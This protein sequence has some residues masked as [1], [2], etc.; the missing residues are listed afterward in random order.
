M[1]GESGLKPGPTKP[2][3]KIRNTPDL[4]PFYSVLFCFYKSDV[5]H[6]NSLNHSPKL[7]VSVTAIYRQ[8]NDGDPHDWSTIFSKGPIFY[9]KNLGFPFRQFSGGD[10]TTFPKRSGRA[11]HGLLD[12]DAHGFNTLRWRFPITKPRHFFLKYIFFYRIRKL[13][14]MCTIRRYNVAFETLRDI[15][16]E[17]WWFAR[18]PIGKSR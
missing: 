10:H 18:H 4:V 2:N 9:F 6:S 11:P 14:W 5:T 7:R 12:D 8:T 17:T 3:P 15:A 1:S 16:F 13:F